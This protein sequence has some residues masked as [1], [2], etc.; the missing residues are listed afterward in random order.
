MREITFTVERDGVIKDYLRRSCGLSGTLIKRVKYGGV[1]VGGVCVGMRATV[2]AG[3]T[4]TVRLPEEEVQ[5]QVLQ[6]DHVPT[7]LRQK[8]R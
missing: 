4:V 2:R 8:G 7:L 6:R 1:L 3:D 5:G